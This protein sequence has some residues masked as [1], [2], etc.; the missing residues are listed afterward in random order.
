[1]G[2]GILGV[3]VSRIKDPDHDPDHLNSILCFVLHLSEVWALLN[4]VLNFRRVLECYL[5]ELLHANNT[6]KLVNCSIIVGALR[7]Q[8]STFN[9]CV[10]ISMP[11]SYCNLNPEI[12]GV[13]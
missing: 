10:V 5:N 2:H 1:L 8:Q 3:I 7:I 9:G 11:L 4:A 13:P 6:D 12:F